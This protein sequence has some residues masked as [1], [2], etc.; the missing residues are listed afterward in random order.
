MVLLSQPHMYESLT[1]GCWLH[2]VV[3]NESDVEKTAEVHHMP[4][5]SPQHTK[6][7]YLSQ[8]LC[9]SSLQGRL[10]DG[11]RHFPK[12][13]HSASKCHPD[14]SLFFP[15]KNESLLR[16]NWYCRHNWELHV[17]WKWTVAGSGRLLHYASV[18]SNTARTLLNSGLHMAQALASHYKG[19]SLSQCA[20]YIFLCLC[21]YSWF[22]LV[23]FLWLCM[24][25]V[26]GRN[27]STFP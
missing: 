21:F 14:S 9:R 18:D 1:W 4:H 23:G 26:K 12:V 7:T 15:P 27:Q 8:D 10:F 24:G 20:N 13:A 3:E 5:F 17:A 22:V 11:L 25:A 16:Q 6:D 19:R 2:P